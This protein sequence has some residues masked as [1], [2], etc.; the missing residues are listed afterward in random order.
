ML[1]ESSKE[2][3]S[4]GLRNAFVYDFASRQGKIGFALLLRASA[5][6]SKLDGTRL[7]VDCQ[8]FPACRGQNRTKASLRPIAELFSPSG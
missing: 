3:L 7:G 8:F 4:A 1:K 2:K 5:I 6:S